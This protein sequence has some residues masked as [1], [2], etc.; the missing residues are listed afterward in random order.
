MKKYHC[1]DCG[2][3]MGEKKSL[4]DVIGLGHEGLYYAVITFIVVLGIAAVV[5]GIT[6]AI[7]SHGESKHRRDE[8]LA[9]QGLKIKKEYGPGGKYVEE[10]VPIVEKEKKE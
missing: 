8:T 3:Q 1:P 4:N 10:V 2:V 9:A 5:L 7:Y 6:Y